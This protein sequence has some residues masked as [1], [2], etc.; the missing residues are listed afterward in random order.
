MTLQKRLAESE[1]RL[2]AA[3]S[4]KNE[5]EKDNAALSKQV[6][7]KENRRKKL[8]RNL[9]NAKE[10]NNKLKNDVARVEK[11]LEKSE[12]AQDNYKK[13]LETARKELNETKAKLNKLTV[14]Q[15]EKSVSEECLAAMQKLLTT[16]SIGDQLVFPPLQTDSPVRILDR[17]GINKTELPFKS[18]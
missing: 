12:A 1:Q 16:A 3:E 9:K 4:E 11:R 8:D 2:A 6:D 10:R 13:R 17:R 7:E 18:A 14:V 5:Y 15:A